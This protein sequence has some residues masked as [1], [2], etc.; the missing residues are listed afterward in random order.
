MSRLFFCAN[1]RFH[2]KMFSSKERIRMPLYNKGVRFFV[3]SLDF[4]GRSTQICIDYCLSMRYTINLT[5]F[6]VSS[7]VQGKAAL[8][9][10]LAVPY[11]C[12]PLQQG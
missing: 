7:S 5:A 10:E 12:N 4:H 9:G 2:V 11:S 6:R 3:L 1:K 8:V